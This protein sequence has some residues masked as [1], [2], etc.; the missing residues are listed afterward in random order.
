MTFSTKNIYTFFC[1]SFLIFFPQNTFSQ[2]KRAQEN[3]LKGELELHL[4]DFKQALLYYDKAILENPTY[5]D[6]YF[7]RG[8]TNYWLDNIDFAERDFART[9]QINP[10]RNDANAYL[11]I[12]F[13]TKKK[14]N[15][16]LP[17]LDKA[18][19][20]NIKYTLAYNY[21]AETYYALQQYEKASTDYT[22]AIQLERKEPK[23]YAGRAKCLL[24]LEKPKEALQDYQQ[25]FAFDTQNTNYVL[26]SAEIAYF[27][28]D[29]PSF[30]QYFNQYEALILK[31]LEN[32]KS[33]NPKKNTQNTIQNTTQK[34]N[35]QQVYA[36]I[37]TQ[38]L[39]W[40]LDCRLKNNNTDNIPTATLYLD[41]LIRR[42]PQNS[43][44]LVQ[45]ARLLVL[46][47]RVP[48]A[49][50]FVTQAILQNPDEVQYYVFCAE[51]YLQQNDTPKAIAYLHSAHLTQPKNAEIVYQLGQLYHQQKQKKEA[52][53]FFELAVNNDFPK[54]KCDKIAMNYMKKAYKKLGIKN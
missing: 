38:Y 9:L 26:M 20:N 36:R 47:K 28:K 7:A 13:Y 52:K 44:F 34:D 40:A 45:K 25:A 16:A 11:G 42:N 43:D 50:T 3:Y 41:E 39:F 29:C 8:K 22:K 1:F 24:A 23:F 48:E 54:E 5:E 33:T 53:Y 10:E 49:I 19:K 17:L 18:L 46:Q 51:L 15:E 21:R 37:D 2:T 30:L 31:N 14:Y 12:I 4:G 32:I 27:L 35:L 6:A